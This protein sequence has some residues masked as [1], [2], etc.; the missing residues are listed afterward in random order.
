[1]LLLAVSGGPDSM[2]LLNDYKKS[3]VVVAHINY[4]KRADSDIDQ[5]IVED[6]CAKYEIP[7]EVL[8]VTKECV[9]N[10][11]KWARD[12]RYEYFKKIYQKYDCKKLLVAHHLDDF[13]E[14][15]IAIEPLIISELKRR[16][17]YMKWML[18][19]LI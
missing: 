12:I 1:M 11:Q 18:L 4:K 9:G 13:I 5:K 16:I 6:F 19:D 14:T 2:A 7:C 17:T 8:V 15:A 10:F 3:K